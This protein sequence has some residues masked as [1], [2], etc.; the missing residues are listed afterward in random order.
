MNVITRRWNS[1]LGN[2]IDRDLRDRERL[3]HINQLVAN[4]L[5]ALIH[6][7][8]ALEHPDARW[9]PDDLVDVLLGQR[10]SIGFE[11][12]RVSRGQTVIGPDDWEA[13]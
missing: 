7:M 1:P 9:C 10:K 6:D 5:D 12:Q 4:L 13:A 2:A 3:E 8:G 11:L